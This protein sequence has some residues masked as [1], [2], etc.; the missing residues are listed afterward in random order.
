MEQV[1]IVAII[2]V[3]A[4]KIIELFVHRKERINLVDKLDFAKETNTDLNQ[5]LGGSIITN[6]ATMWGCLLVGIGLGVLVGYVI[7]SSCGLYSSIDSQN[8]RHLN[9]QISV[10][11]ASSTLIFGGAG[12][13]TSFL[14][15]KKRQKSQK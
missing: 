14:I 6:K 10:I 9:E 13:L 5:I 15:D 11:Y 8:M 1:F 3:V 7:S 12:L 4:Y 2:F